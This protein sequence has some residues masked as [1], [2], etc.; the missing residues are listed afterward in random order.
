MV[1]ILHISDSRLIAD[2]LWGKSLC[3][4]WVLH[5]GGLPPAAG[6]RAGQKKRLVRGE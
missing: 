1:S 3:R 4:V 2:M 6:F 5:T